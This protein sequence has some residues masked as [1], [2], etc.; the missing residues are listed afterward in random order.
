MPSSSPQPARQGVS[1]FFGPA[2]EAQRLRFSDA[3]LEA[4]YQASVGQRVVS[5]YRE[6][7]AL[8][9]L[10]ITIIV[11]ANEMLVPIYAYDDRWLWLL[12]RLVFSLAPFVVMYAIRN[13]AVFEQFCDEIAISTALFGNVAQA[14]LL[15]RLQLFDQLNLNVGFVI[16][17]TTAALLLPF[18]QSVVAAI[19]SA[20]PYH[21]A[22]LSGLYEYLPAPHQ[23]VLYAYMLHQTII[24]CFFGMV[25]AYMLNVY[26]REIFQRERILREQR[27]QL[28]AA[29]EELNT[30]NRAKDELLGIAAHD[31]RNPLTSI[32]GLVDLMIA[33]PSMIRNE[34]KAA[35][36]LR[37]M[38]ASARQMSRLI[39][40]L[41]E[42]NR[43]D[44][45][46]LQLAMR[47]LDASSHGAQIVANYQNKS[48][49]KNITIR[50]EA[51][52]P[53][54]ALADDLALTQVL[55]NLLSNAV[56]FSPTGSAVLVRVLKHNNRARIE[57]KDSGPGLSA[58]DQAR[59]FQKFTPLNARPTGGEPSIGL[60]L[61]IVKR[62]VDEMQG[63]VWCESELGSGAMFV[64]EL[65]VGEQS[66]GA[67]E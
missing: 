43:M 57:V 2:S 12:T 1:S 52:A 66:L 17:F 7:L 41:L 36:M 20:L 31:L 33:T 64:V 10:V 42:T 16:L 47:Q 13:T 11:T 38:G 6:R 18:R 14:L 5:N 65:G 60:G 34:E 50:L 61:S 30:V 67:G 32:V 23:S 19:F 49:T 56:K 27:E 58:S 26:D 28:E 22:Y 21:V 8:I 4:A 55:D 62:L 24:G 44:Q 15:A 54:V 59:L 25:V 39:T 51:A 37:I 3:A 35:S 29:L 9:W 63:R 48:A 40:N 45:G 46:K 53:V